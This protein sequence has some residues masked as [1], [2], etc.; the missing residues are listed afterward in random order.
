MAWHI[1]FPLAAT[2]RLHYDNVMTKE[3]EFAGLGHYPGWIVN[4]RAMMSFGSVAEP[5]SKTGADLV[6]VWDAEGAGQN[7]APW[8][9]LYRR[10]PK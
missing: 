9:E 5:Y 4:E 2:A 10:P 3:S 6:L 8:I 7:S 1:N